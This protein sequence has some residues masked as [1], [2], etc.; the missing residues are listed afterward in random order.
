MDE[1]C[2]IVVEITEDHRGT[3]L[4][5]DLIGI[6]LAC[7]EWHIWHFRH[8]HRQ[9]KVGDKVCLT[10]MSEG[11]R[12]SFCSEPKTLDWTKVGF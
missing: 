12:G 1:L 3:L 9:P 4:I 7:D 8:C 5:V 2:G 6:L 10:S 11:W